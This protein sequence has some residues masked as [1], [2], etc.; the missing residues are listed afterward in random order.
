[1]N[2]NDKML[3]SNRLL[4][5]F[6]LLFLTSCSS[7]AQHSTSAKEI[8]HAYFKVYEQRTDFSEFMSFYDQNVQFEDMVY[9]VSSSTKNDL[10]E[11]FDWSR[12]NFSVVGG[13]PSLVVNKL[14]VEGN[15][16]VASGYFNQF[17]YNEA[18]M[19]PW[20]F[21]ITLEFND[22]GKIIRQ[23]DWINYTPRKNFLGG[24]N[25]NQKL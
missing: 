14:V 6:C 10:K 7:S 1:M 3:N 9:G 4:L 20:R 18:E 19:G 25:L 21:I 11:F 12:G 15:C 5:V 17:N 24:E 8:A 23:T 2:E 22:A 16:V 13:K